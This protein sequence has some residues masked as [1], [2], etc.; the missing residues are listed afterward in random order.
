MAEEVK[1]WNIEETLNEWSDE[2]WEVTYV[3]TPKGSDKVTI[4]AKRP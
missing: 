2:G 1:K 3:I 4:G